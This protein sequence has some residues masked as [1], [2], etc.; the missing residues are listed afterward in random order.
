MIALKFKVFSDPQLP[1]TLMTNLNRSEF[2]YQLREFQ[3]GKKEETDLNL[4][5][6]V[7][8]RVTVNSGIVFVFS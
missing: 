1:Q 5:E 6:R 7:L 8:F 4:C 2:L 3:E